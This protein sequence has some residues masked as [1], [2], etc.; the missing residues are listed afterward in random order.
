VKLD[1][2][3]AST[4]DLSLLSTSPTTRAMDHGHNSPEP[5]MP[6][7]PSNLCW[8][9]P[10]GFS[11]QEHLNLE[12]LPNF[13]PRS[14]FSC[15]NDSRHL[16]NG[17]VR[18]YPTEHQP[19]IFSNDDEHFS[20]YTPNLSRHFVIPSIETADETII[21]E[22][23][24]LGLQESLLNTPANIDLDA[25]EARQRE[26]RQKWK[27]SPNTDSRKQ[28]IHKDAKTH[29]PSLMGQ[30]SKSQGPKS[31]AQG[32]GLARSMPVPRLDP[33]PR[34]RSKH[35]ESL[36]GWLPQSQL[37]SSPGPLD[38]DAYEQAEVECLDN[39]S[40]FAQ[41]GGFTPLA[42][43]I[44]SPSFSSIDDVPS[45]SSFRP[46][47][48]QNPNLYSASHLS[49]TFAPPDQLLPVS[50]ANITRDG[51]EIPI[52][53]DHSDE[54]IYRS[55]FNHASQSP[56]LWDQQNFDHDLDAVRWRNSDPSL[57]ND[58]SSC[59]GGQVPLPDYR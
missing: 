14:E 48:S 32:Q 26:Y 17:F 40:S 24:I 35:P 16:R 27:K 23:E 45:C 54:I 50:E 19:H 8:N 56:L 6:D 10:E 13:C 46:Q 36:V 11:Y 39:C 21:Q 5:Y 1:S 2:G 52:L 37:V 3:S 4:V 58:S 57:V 43:R 44:S 20:Q 34:Y 12:Y 41:Y 59:G 53:A 7:S 30:D 15:E 31:Q 29:G 51:F 25:L 47:N 28:G 18:E 22:N 49:N 55:S 9:L 33:Q 38:E 42:P